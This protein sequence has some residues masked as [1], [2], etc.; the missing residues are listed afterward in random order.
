M[1]SSSSAGHDDFLSSQTTTP[2][3][4]DNFSSPQVPVTKSPY[5]TSTPFVSGSQT[6][7]K[8]AT[9]LPQ[10]SPPLTANWVQSPP[11]PVTNTVPPTPPFPSSSLPQSPPQS[12]SGWPQTPSSAASLSQSTP[13]SSVPGTSPQPSSHYS[14]YSSPQQVKSGMSPNVAPTATVEPVKPHWFYKKENSAWRPF[15][16]IDSENLEQALKTPSASGDRIIATDGGRY[17][18]NLDKRLRYPLYW[19]E[20]VSVVRRCTWFYKGDAE[21]KLVPYKEDMAARLEVGCLSK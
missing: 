1:A 10:S 20:G 3:V 9:T 13:P 17:D 6:P 14:S 15:S 19:E 4:A 8:P 12:S 5:Q 2:S 11:P 16:Y 21:S 18:V 7:P